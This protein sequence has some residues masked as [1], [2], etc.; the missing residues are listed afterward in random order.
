MNTTIKILAIDDIQDNLISLNAL[1]KEAFPAAKLFTA[2]NGEDGM[3]IARAEEPAVILLDIVMPEMDGFEVCQKLKADITLCDIP[4]VFITALKGDKENRIRALECGAEAFLT[5][6]ID[7]SELTAQIRAMVKIRSANLE[8]RNEKQ[9]LAILIEEQTRELKKAYKTTLNLLDDLRNEN[10]ARKNS[11]EALRESEDKFKYVFDFSSVGKSITLTS[12]EINVNQAFCNIVGY[13]REELQQKKWQEITHPD[14]IEISQQAIDSLVSGKQESVRFNKRFIHKN[15]NIIWVDL[16]SSLRYNKVNEPL[17]LMS[18]LIDITEQKQAEEKL[19]ESEKRLKTIYETVGD[20]IFHLKVIDTGKYCFESVNPRFYQITGL[21]QEQV[22][23]KMVDEVIPE[24]SLSMVLK[25]YKKAIEGKKI[26]IWEETSVYPTGQLIGEVSISPVFDEI[27]KCTHLVGSVHDI[28][29]RKKAEEALLESE[30]KFALVFRDAPVLISITDMDDG[31]YLDVNEQAIHTSGFS[32]EEIIGHTTSEFGWISVADR[33]MLAR[34]TLEKGHVTDLEMEF[35]TKDGRI[36]YGL[37]NGEQITIGG[38]NCLLTVTIDITDRKIAEQSLRE[39]EARLKRAELASKSGNWEFHLDSGSILA[40]EG[41]VKIYGVEKDRFNYETIKSIP[42]PEYRQILDEALKNLIKSNTPYDI[43]FK[44]RKVDTGEIKDIHSVASY[45]NE[46]KILFGVIQ[47]ITERKQAEETLRTTKILLE[48]TLEQSPVPMVLVSMPDAIIRIA[49]PACLKLLGIEDEPSVIGIPLLKLKPSWQDFDIQG[50]QGKVGELPLA[51]SLKGQKTEGEERC[52]IRKDGS[53][54]YELV[55]G[56]PIID[57]S[58]KVIAGYLIMMDITDRKQVEFTLQ[59]KNILLT[60]AKEKAEENEI[61]LKMAQRVSNTGAWDWDIQKNSFYWSEEF[62]EL[63]ELPKDTTA[64]FDAWSK[65]LHPEDVDMASKR[66]TE[67]IENKTDLLNEYRIILPNNEIRWIRAFGSTYYENDKPTRMVGLCQDITKQKQAEQELIVAKEKAEESEIVLIEAQKT[68][69]IGHWNWDLEKQQLTWSDEIFNI[70]G[71]SRESFDV[72][73]ENFEKTIHPDDLEDFLFKR[74]EGLLKDN[75]INVDHR[76]IRPNGE[77]RFVQER[78]KILRT[79]N[80]QPISIFG[81]VQDITELKLT[82]IELIKAKEKAEES[83][84]LK[85]AFLANMSHEI[86]TPMN[87]IMGFAS[88][89]PEEESKDL[90]T[91]YANIIVRSSEQLVHIIDDIVLYS[92]LQTKL[93]SYIPSPFN[94]QNLLTDVK[95]SFNL[96]DFK[97]GVELIIETDSD[98]PVWIRSDYEKI[99]QIFTNLVSN[100]FKYT[101]KGSI[102]IGFTSREDNIE[103]FVKDTGVG[104][105]AD[106]LEKVF[107]RFYR[108]SNVNKGVIS[109][110]G[111]GLS[112]VK[113]LVEL[114]GGKIWVESDPYG[115]RGIIGST[116][117]FTLP[118]YH[119]QQD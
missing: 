54:R 86:R 84:R 48:Q 41:A 9:R 92:R 87:S 109:G 113:E 119:D 31:T 97:K 25:K 103:F 96:P 39:S 27:G 56:F 63:F 77:I 80:K 16:H 102:T 72:T 34:K 44:I 118:K 38:R 65:S 45:D 21:K 69:H 32:R 62:L 49:N 3:E 70:F 47:D 116:F 101:T 104:I 4:V 15:G 115:H 94:V 105:L 35:R 17:Y 8:K 83:D 20:V 110:T 22:V 98:L 5:K 74:S 7:E 78:S 14:D 46:K 33:I 57:D 24:P 13:T 61:R 10:E 40:S 59:E 91:N 58:G 79:E 18:T 67:A 11:E 71:L 60:E 2:L 95:Q 108:G 111:L 28:T 37:V 117:Y 1:I 114:L 43:E 19:K 112:I 26:V 30:E 82:E 68:A 53:I 64:G 76:I 23:G 50:R 66:I 106:E 93:L 6:P 99:R 55:N 85:T 90:M 36:L 52:I 42:L 51:R 73:P 81:T 107:D 29:G 89:L 88:L 12:G 100:A 75:E